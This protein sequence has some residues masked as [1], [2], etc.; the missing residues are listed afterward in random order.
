MKK[1]TILLAV[2]MAAIAFCAWAAFQWFF[3]RFYVGPNQIAI[4]TVKSGR[5]L[6]PG[7]ILARPGQRGVQEAVLAEGRHFL[8]PISTEHQILPTTII[9]PGKVGVVTSKVGTELPAGEFLADEGQKG[10]RRK[11]LSPGKYRLNPVGYK[12]D[13]VDAISIPIG[14]V[15]AVTSLSGVQAPPGEF[16]KPGQKGVCEDILQPGLYYV[17]PY[18]YKVDVVEVGINQISLVGK[19][20]TGVITKAQIASSNDVVGELGRSVLKEQQA[21]RDAY[22]KAGEGKAGLSEAESSR[23]ARGRSD[24]RSLDRST[25]PSFPINAPMASNKQINPT[26]VPG[27]AAFILNQYV[28]FPSKDGFEISVDMTVEFELLPGNIAWVF[29]KYGDLPAAVDKVILPQ[30]LSLSRLKGSEYGARDF[31]FGEGREAFQNDLRDSLAAVL[32]EKRILVNN[33]LIRNVNVPMEILDP[34][35][36]A[37]VAKE[38]DLTNQEKQNTAKKQAELNTQLS[39]IDQA[40]QQVAQETLKLKAEIQADERK[41]VAEIG[42]ETLKQVAL[43]AKETAAIRAEKTMTLG[44]ATASRISLVEG[45]KALGF[46]KKINAFGNAEAY[47]LWTLANGLDPNLTLNIFHSGPGTLW[48]DLDKARLGDVGGAKL[49]QSQQKG[50]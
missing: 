17:N 32:K 44:K 47:N 6:E 25:G 7:Q 33:A 23:T 1:Q 42:G 35:Q 19:K 46:Q 37:S 38:R 39:L 16:A 12:V 14:Y 2:S 18:A 5:P 49:L 34:I 41:Q 8:N 30:I 11:V 22:F 40:G 20:G 28:E 27:Q 43:I 45:E 13:V 24:M 50:N 4:V 10:I 48:T 36:Q 21:K 9:P 26:A 15:G 29:R 3:C 31:I